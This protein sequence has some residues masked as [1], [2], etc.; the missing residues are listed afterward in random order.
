M[1]SSS[2]IYTADLDALRLEI[3]NK[4]RELNLIEESLSLYSQEVV[5]VSQRLDTLI[6]L[7]LQAA[8]LL[9]FNEERASSRKRGDGNGHDIDRRII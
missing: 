8:R 1:K 9:R 2:D 4:R 7:Y 6:V 5:K 3:E